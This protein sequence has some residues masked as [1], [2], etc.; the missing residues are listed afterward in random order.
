MKYALVVLA[1]VRV[2]WVSS[3]K[4]TMASSAVSLVAINQRLARPGMAKGSMAGSVMRLSIRPGAM[5]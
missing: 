4:P 5:P 3:L 1:A 2:S